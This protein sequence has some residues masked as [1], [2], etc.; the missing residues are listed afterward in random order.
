MTAA[1]LYY[2]VK[3]DDAAMYHT[4]D[5]LRS[6][7][8]RLARGREDDHP[9][10]HLILDPNLND[11][12]IVTRLRGRKFYPMGD[13]IVRRKWQRDLPKTVERVQQAICGIENLPTS[14]DILVVA[15]EPMILVMA[16]LFG[17]NEEWDNA[18]FEELKYSLNLG[19]LGLIQV[20]RTI[21]QEGSKHISSYKLTAYHTGPYDGKTLKP[22]LV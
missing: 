20:R 1:M 19:P 2:R 13:E 17:K 7:V 21:I 6:S 16:A 5:T 9:F 15:A 18:L 14:H 11:L 4:K 22:I 8:G 10:K 3:P 12:T